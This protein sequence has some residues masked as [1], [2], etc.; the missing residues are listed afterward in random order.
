MKRTAA[1]MTLVALVA[2][3][4]QVD[5]IAPRRL[6]EVVDI[7]PPVLSPD[8]TKVAYRT[9]QASIERNTY[10]TVWYV[11]G[12]D[13]G[14]LP[15]RVAEGG[16]PLRDAAGI[17]LLAMATWSPDGRWIYY[18]ALH[19]G[20]VAVWRTAADGARTEPVATDA[21]DVRDFVLAADGLTL[22][23]SVGA[24]R[25]QVE[26]AELAEYDQGIRVD[27]TTPVG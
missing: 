25:E 5:A 15:V 3:L 13:E 11:Q 22:H 4:G 24:P 26:D 17:S 1:A 20:K 18:R 16:L 23:Y 10:D 7:G 12:L 6:V 27:E 21:A 8:G 14:A 9:E 2:T 19:A